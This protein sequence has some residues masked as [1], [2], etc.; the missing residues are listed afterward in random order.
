MKKGIIFGLVIILLLLY[1]YPG[2][3][4]ENKIKKMMW[5]VSF[6][7]AQNSCLKWDLLKPFLPIFP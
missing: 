4:S 1:G 3:A 7:K 2:R 6:P 5:L